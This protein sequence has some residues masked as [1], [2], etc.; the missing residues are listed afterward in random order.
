MLFAEF[1]VPALVLSFLLWIGLR[2]LWYSPLLFGRVLVAGDSPGTRDA[3]SFIAL[4]GNMPVAVIVVFAV[5]AVVHW[6]DYAGGNVTWLT[7]LAVGWVLWLG[8]TVPPYC[9]ELIDGTRKV[10]V[11][12]IA[13]GYFLV[14]YGIIGAVIG[15]WQ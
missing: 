4:L 9:L 7:G 1:N 12:L 3:F 6:F 11:S 13:L 10:A 8:F 2:S 5:N 14:G 15:A